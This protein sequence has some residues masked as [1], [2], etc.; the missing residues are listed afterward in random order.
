MSKH[1]FSSPQEQ[2]PTT[3]SNKQITLPSVVESYNAMN[4]KPLYTKQCELA[5]FREGS[6]IEKA[7][8]SMIPCVGNAQRRQVHRDN[9][10]GS[11]QV[12][13]RRE[14]GGKVGSECYWTQGLSF[15]DDKIVL[16]LIVIIAVQLCGDMKTI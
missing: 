12:Q 3:P 6:S 8:R 16:E 9:V 4:V 10:N 14:S 5:L 13:G 7:T 11:F 2:C 15:G 1:L